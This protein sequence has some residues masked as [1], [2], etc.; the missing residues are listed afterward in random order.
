MAKNT[1][2]DMHYHYHYYNGGTG[3]AAGT[4]GAA[5]MQAPPPPPPGAAPG[6]SW[7]NLHRHPNADS[8][9]KG[10]LI[11]AGAAYLLTNEKAQRTIIRAAVGLWGAVQGA[12]EEVKERVRDAEA[13]VAA[14][15]EATAAE[16]E[17]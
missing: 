17:P 14:A 15:T 5:D 9:I 1:G 4:G 2:G 7:T 6:P 13:E 10:L 12:V 16:G 11:G 3:P 8:L